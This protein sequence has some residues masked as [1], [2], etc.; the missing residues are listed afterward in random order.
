MQIK[1]LG[2]FLNAKTTKKLSSPLSLFG[3]FDALGLFE[4][5][6][7]FDVELDLLLSTDVLESD[8]LEL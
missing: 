4:L 5:L 3:A 1:E 7:L 8:F 6:L 2:K